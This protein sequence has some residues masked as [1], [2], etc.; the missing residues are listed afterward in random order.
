[1]TRVSY[2]FLYCGQV[3]LGAPNV[4]DASVDLPGVDTDDFVQDES[5]G[6]V[7]FNPSADS[8]A[9]DIGGDLPD[10]TDFIGT[11]FSSYSLHPLKFPHPSFPPCL[12]INFSSSFIL[13][14]L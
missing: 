2:S 11:L 3:R 10:D 7:F 6:R 1:M 12:F 13:D 8:I 14:F 4:D 9:L 5:G